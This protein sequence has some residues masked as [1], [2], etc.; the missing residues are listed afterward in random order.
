MSGE[1]RGRGWRASQGWGGSEIIKA[2]GISPEHKH[3]QCPHQK[4]NGDEQT[5]LTETCGRGRPAPGQLP[6]R[7]EVLRT[8][9]LSVSRLH[10][11]CSGGSEKASATQ[12]YLLL[13]PAP[14]ERAKGLLSSTHSESPFHWL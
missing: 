3:S 7:L 13:N 5:N 4:A 10:F 9:F 11:L 12:A 14:R 6:Q 1:C 8:P 2:A